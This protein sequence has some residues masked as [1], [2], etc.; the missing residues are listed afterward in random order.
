M[1]LDISV[2]DKDWKSV[3]HL[4]KL[5]RQA[6]RAVVDDDDV[7]V[8]I[9]F[10]GDAEILELNKQWRGKATSTNVLSFPL[11]RG[12][13]VVQGEE[14]PLGD[15]V[16][17]YGTVAREAGEQRK[18][19]TNHIIHLIIHG[20][21]HLLGYDHKND[22]EAHIMEARETETLARLGIEDPYRS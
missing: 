1:N 7:R 9:L 13:P 11:P 8:S 4:R 19:V 17:A 16:M 14:R 6:V 15:I 12:T 2:A 18:P 21:L 3:P 20:V 22:A 5:A 10:T